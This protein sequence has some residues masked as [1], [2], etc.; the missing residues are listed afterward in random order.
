MKSSIL[1]FVALPLR[2]RGGLKRAT[3]MTAALVLMGSGQIWAAPIVGVTFNSSGG[4][5][6]WTNETGLGTT[7]NLP[8]ETGANSGIS[9]TTSVTGA[10]GPF[11]VSVNPATI[12]SG[13]PNLAGING[14]IYGEDSFTAALSGLQAG[15]TYNVWLFVTRE[16]DPTNQ[17]VNITG[18]GSTNFAQVD[19]STQEL[20][21]NDAIGSSSVPLG[22]YAVPIVANGSG[23]IAISI[24][25]NDGDFGAAI[26]G[27]ALEQVSST[28]EPGTLSLLA[29]GAVSL[30]GFGWRRRSR[31][32]V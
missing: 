27:L 5:P 4:A 16:N 12:P 9:L 32:A 17:L 8:Y 10:S 3:L 20:I 28:P 30:A 29:C 15:G 11:S 24:A 18:A 23:Q 31:A 26:S 21:V 14:N 6:Q 25:N 22:F 7:N 19:G 2:N 13:D 1:T